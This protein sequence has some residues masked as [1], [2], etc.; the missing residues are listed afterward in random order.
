MIRKENSYGSPGVGE[1]NLEFK[2]PE[3]L[4]SSDQ[5]AKAKTV[6]T[7]KPGNLLQNKRGAS[8]P[9][10]MVHK[11]PPKGDV[12]QEDINKNSNFKDPKPQNLTISGFEP[13]SE[14]QRKAGLLARNE[15]QKDIV[16]QSNFKT[17]GNISIDTSPQKTTR[18]IVLP[19]SLEQQ[20][21]VCKKELAMKTK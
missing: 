7:V 17:K 14:E 2:L 20:K 5:S 18:S 11:S 4:R 9:Q 21:G 13:S 19:T 6:S 16:K 10:Q 15:K 12:K 8:S 3:D 1:K